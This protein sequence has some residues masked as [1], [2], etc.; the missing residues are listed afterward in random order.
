MENK[1]ISDKDAMALLEE[2]FELL[3]VNAEKGNTPICVSYTN[4]V[5][6]M[7]TPDEWTLKYLLGR[8]GM[9]GK[10][11]VVMPVPD[12]FTLLIFEV[13]KEEKLA[14]IIH[15]PLCLINELTGHMA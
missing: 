11:M 13:T 6:S 8:P 2:G 7:V 14:E 12:E 5:G 3:R 1:N 15:P 10:T 4:G 9:R